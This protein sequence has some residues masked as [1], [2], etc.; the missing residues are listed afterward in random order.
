MWADDGSEGSRGADGRGHPVRVAV[1]G[2]RAAGD[3]EPDGE[4]ALHGR[5]EGRGHHL[6][7]GQQRHLAAERPPGAQPAPPRAHHARAALERRQG[8]SAVR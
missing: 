7:G 4:A 5:R 8:H 2:G 3:A 6:G 1:G